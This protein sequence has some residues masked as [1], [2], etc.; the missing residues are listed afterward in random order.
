MEKRYKGELTVRLR[1]AF[2]ETG[3][4]NKKFAERLAAERGQNTDIVDQGN[5]GFWPGL[6]RRQRSLTSLNT[7]SPVCKGVDRMEQRLCQIGGPLYILLS[8]YR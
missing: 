7:S 4:Q 8:V 3:M 1:R 6:H 5:L 2:H